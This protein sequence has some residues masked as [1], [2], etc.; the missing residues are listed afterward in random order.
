MIS[1]REATALDIPVL[2]SLDREYFAHTAWPA[3]QFRGEI[4][5]S[6]RFFLVAEK[7]Q[8]IIAYAGAFL[9]IGRAHV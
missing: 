8:K 4:G 5:K 2:V 1:Y 3:E 9:Q 6:T 7:D